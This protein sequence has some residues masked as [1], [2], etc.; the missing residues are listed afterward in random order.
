MLKNLSY[1]YGFLEKE[2]EAL[3]ALNK[4]LTIEQELGD[5]NAQAWTLL[6]IGLANYT[7]LN[8]Q[9]ALQFSER[10]LRIF[11]ETQ[12]LDGEA[13]SLSFMTKLY[14]KQNANLAVIFGKQSVPANIY[15][16]LRAKIKG[17]D[18]ELQQSFLKSN[19]SVYRELVDLLIAQGS[20]A[21]AEQVLAMLK[22][23]EYFD[24]VRR[25]RR[26]N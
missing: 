20:F 25:D 10:A 4:A 16:E 22:E 14:S 17:L 12:D 11:R 15:Q 24:F 3:T 5:R 9:Q 6:R 18:K 8:K 1:V 13:V 19:E 23:E 7:Q 21:Q 26:R 2:A